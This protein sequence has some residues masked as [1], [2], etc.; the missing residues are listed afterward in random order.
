MGAEEAKHDIVTSANLIEESTQN[1]PL[2]NGHLEKL[3][4]VQ[5]E[6]TPTVP[7]EIDARLRTSNFF[8]QNGDN[9]FDGN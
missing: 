1:E 2:K 3:S 9:M 6:I 4:E 5:N 8:S 7:Q